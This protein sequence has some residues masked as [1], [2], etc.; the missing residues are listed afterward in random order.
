M[1]KSRKHCVHTFG[2]VYRVYVFSCSYL[3]LHIETSAKNKLISLSI[4][5]KLDT[6]VF[7][8]L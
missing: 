2:C 8:C 7:N 5:C 3:H 4:S 1:D 6:F